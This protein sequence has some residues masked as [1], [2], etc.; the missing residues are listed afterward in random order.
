MLITEK[1]Q[2]NMRPV[3]IFKV[4]GITLNVALC[5]I[6]IEPSWLNEPQETGRKKCLVSFPINRAD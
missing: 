3:L 2:M 5:G 4:S 6:N 1:C